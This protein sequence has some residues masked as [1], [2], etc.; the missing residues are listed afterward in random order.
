M[1][2]EADAVVVP[3][4]GGSDVLEIVSRTVP[5][6]AAGEIRVRVA[7]A[8]VNF[9]NVYQRE[10]IY[11]G[12]PPF[13]LGNE[14]AGT[15]ESVGA[16]VGHVAVGDTVA[17]AQAPGSFAGLAVVDAAAT[18]P[19]PDGVGVKT[20]A[21][22]MLQGLTAHYLVNSTYL[23]QPGD[24]VLVHAAAGG[25]GQ[26]LV[27]MA[28]AKG[29]TVIGTVSTEEKAVRSRA[30]GVDQVVNYSRVHDIAGAVRELT[31]GVGVAAVYDGVGRST[32]DASLSCLRVRGTLALFGGASGQVPP[33]D[34]QRL[35][36]AGSVFVTRPTLAHHISTRAEL[37]SRSTD[38]FDAI[39]DRSLS[40]EIGG[41]YPLAR[42]RVAYDDLEGRRTTGKLLLIP[43]AA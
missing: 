7:A 40:V 37:L 26:L 17:W 12:T 6:P 27:Q 14:G 42:V 9:V 20:A 21:A 41:E 23:V 13:V 2:R 22:S 10:G 34:L 31:A 32:F 8:G 33:V 43:G 25:V 4:H 38:L 28:K 39:V 11:P 19:V 35:S 30:V 15:V 36:S 5:D 3:R 24:V 1:Q 18:V 29:A 16:G